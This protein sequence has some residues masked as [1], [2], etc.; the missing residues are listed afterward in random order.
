[1]PSRNRILKAIGAREF[2]CLIQ[3]ANTLFTMLLVEIVGNYFQKTLQTITA[4]D[5]HQVIS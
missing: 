1:M 2:C 5:V 3:Y 4:T